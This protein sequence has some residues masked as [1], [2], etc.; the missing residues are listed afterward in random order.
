MKD[1]ERADSIYRCSD[2]V[3]TICIFIIILTLFFK[4]GNIYLDP[5]PY[6]VPILTIS[7]I[8]KKGE[9]FSISVLYFVDKYNEY[10]D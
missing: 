8:I 1:G 4:N 3:A 6:P 7:Y 2:P 10:I 9:V 5:I